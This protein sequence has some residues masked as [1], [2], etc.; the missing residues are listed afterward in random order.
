MKFLFT[1]ALLYLAYRI[2]FV[3]RA[4]VRSFPPQD[5]FRPHPPSATP[6]RQPKSE[7]EYIDYEEV[8]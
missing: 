6:S 7:G 1:L 5:R 3:R 4:P 2:F 8:D